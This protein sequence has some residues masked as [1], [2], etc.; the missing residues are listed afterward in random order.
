MLRLLTTTSCVFAL[1]FSGMAGLPACLLADV[2]LGADACPCMR[3]AR[4]RANQA[5][6]T[7]EHLPGCSRCARRT[8]PTESSSGKPQEPDR[9]QHRGK[10]SC[11]AAHVQPLIEADAGSGYP[12][13]ELQVAVATLPAH[14]ARTAVARKNEASSQST[15]RGPPLPTAAG[16]VNL[17]LLT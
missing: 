5:A 15:E 1:A 13:G 12:A 9:G 14:D 7:R 10:D 4:E 8:P 3:A 11:A 17:P 2:V 6:T 16:D